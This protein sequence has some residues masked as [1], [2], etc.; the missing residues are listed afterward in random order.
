MNSLSVFLSLLSRKKV[1]QGRLQYPRGS[2]T[3]TTNTSGLLLF[4]FSFLFLPHFVVDENSKKYPWY[5][6]DKK[7]SVPEQ[8][9]LTGNDGSSKSVRRIRKRKQ[10]RGKWCVVVTGGERHSLL[11]VG[12]RGVYWF[13]HLACWMVGKKQVGSFT[14]D[15]RL[16]LTT[17][18]YYKLATLCGWYIIFVIMIPERQ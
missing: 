5:R 2:H 15:P 17:V 4:S 16:L 1:F 11:R 9:Q 7:N 8:L 13:F 10:E 6:H 3:W 12:G 18:V 14:I